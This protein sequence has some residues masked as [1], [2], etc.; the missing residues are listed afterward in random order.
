M[1]KVSN[2]SKIFRTE[3][4]ETTALDGVS[5]EIKDNNDI[6]LMDTEKVNFSAKD[7]KDY[8]YYINIFNEMSSQ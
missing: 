4:I 7:L 1:I 3:E 8:D 6:I 2:F 5:F